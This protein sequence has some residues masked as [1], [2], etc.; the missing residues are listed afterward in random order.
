MTIS[1]KLIDN[2]KII[3]KKVLKAIVDEANAS[4][5][6]SIDKSIAPIKVIVRNSLESCPEISSLNGGTLRADFGIP[7]GKD[8]T[9]SIVR[10]ISNSVFISKKKFSAVGN[11]IS[12]G[13]TIGVQ[14]TDY[15]NLSGLGTT[16]LEKGGSLPWLD[17]LINLGD[18]VIIADFGVTYGPFGRSGQ[19]RMSVKKRPFKVDTAFSGTPEDNFITRALDKRASEIESA[20][21]RS[22]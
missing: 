20:I 22:L 2:I 9:T 18:S 8:V 16:D 19:A 12:G 13:I 3:E 14:P 5:F 10:A 15:A 11:N 7:G 6:K 21:R 1:L 4:L 17:W